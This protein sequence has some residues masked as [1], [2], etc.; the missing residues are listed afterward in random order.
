M[1][2]MLKNT[3]MLWHNYCLNISRTDVVNIG[4]RLVKEK[5][6]KKLESVL[7]SKSKQTA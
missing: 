5:L 1:D 2:I 4:I 3:G 7:W 6:D